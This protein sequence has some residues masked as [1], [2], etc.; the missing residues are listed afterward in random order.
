VKWSDYTEPARIRA[1]VAA[2]LA[3]CAALG[4]VLPFDLPGVA[5]ALILIL[6]VA[7]PVVQG[8]VTRAAVYSP[9]AKD[10]AVGLAKAGLSEGPLG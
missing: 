2:V 5:E 10:T 9:A 8:E 7:F 3:L 4:I 6:A 1:A